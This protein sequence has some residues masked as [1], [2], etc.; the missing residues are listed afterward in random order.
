MKMMRLSS[1]APNPSIVIRQPI[2]WT[3]CNSW[4][5]FAHHHIAAPHNANFHR[6]SS[7]IEW[8]RRMERANRVRRKDICLITSNL[9][10]HSRGARQKRCEE[11]LVLYDDIGTRGWLPRRVS[12]SAVTGSG[13]GG[14]ETVP[15]VQLL[16]SDAWLTGLV[17]L[18]IVREEI[19]PVIVGHVV[20]VALRAV[21]D[22]R[23]S[24]GTNVVGFSIVIPGK[25]L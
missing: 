6:A 5:S 13:S 3:A 20:H 17:G 14:R 4:A 24:N 10:R 19:T 7:P 12:C 18:D 1:G 16:F 9:H 22:P 2:G 11:D 8:Y 21:G 23:L 25:N 15:E